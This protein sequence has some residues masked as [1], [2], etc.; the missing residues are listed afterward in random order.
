[1]DVGRSHRHNAD[2]TSLPAAAAALS[3]ALRGAQTSMEKQGGAN[4]AVAHAL[5]QKKAKLKQQRRG[6]CA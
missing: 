5:A 2:D 3:A 6:A 4:K 1:L